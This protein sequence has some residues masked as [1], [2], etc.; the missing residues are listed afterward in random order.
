MY[1]RYMVALRLGYSTALNIVFV[2]F[3]GIQ[4]SWDTE[5]LRYEVYISEGDFGNVLWKRGFTDFSS[6]WYII[7][8]KC[9]WLTLRFVSEIIPLTWNFDSY[10]RID[11][12]IILGLI[13]WRIMCFSMSLELYGG[14]M[15][16]GVQCI[17]TTTT[18]FEMKL[19]IID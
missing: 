9:N 6:G 8:F 13:H 5:N 17:I 14:A 1:C 2:Y 18:K 11:C 4:S 16:F 12:T 15:C 19:D 7:K 3:T 10:S